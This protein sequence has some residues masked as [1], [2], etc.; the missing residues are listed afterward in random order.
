[1]SEHR[2]PESRASAG[3]PA[4]DAAVVALDEAGRQ[5]RAP[6]AAAIAGLLFAVLFTAALVLLRSQPM[7]TAGDVELVRLYS[8]GQD[9]PALIGGLYLAPFA[10]IMF[11]WFIAVIRDQLGE[12][13]DRFFATVF[14]G[15]GVLFVALMFAAT[16]VASAPSVGV[17]YLDQAPPTANTTALLRALSYT[18]LFAFAT[19][20]AAVFLIA[21]ATIGLRSRVFPRWFAVTGYLLGILLLVVVTAWDWIIMVLPAW[22]AVVSLYILRRER[23]R[24][25]TG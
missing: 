21:T 6:W 1:M 3:A 13:E 17:R 24:R 5:L 10:G 12:R 4:P 16:A 23:A 20:A 25:R 15:S 22:V 7:I 14:F 8:T 19:R 2:D 18:F 9:L 11:L